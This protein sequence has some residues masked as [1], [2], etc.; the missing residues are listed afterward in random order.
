MANRLLNRFGS[1]SRSQRNLTAFGLSVLVGFSTTVPLTSMACA[2]SHPTSHPINN[3]PAI[4][5]EASP[6]LIEV[7][8]GIHHY[9]LPSGQNVY[10]KP[11]VSQPIITLDTWVTTGSANETE[12]TNGVSHFLEHLLFKG[13]NKLAVGEMD[14]QLEGMGAQFNAATSLD[15]T[16]YY[17]KTPT[18]GFEKALAMHA[19]MLLQ[20]RLPQPELDRERK[21]VQEEINRSQDNPSSQLF[22]ALQKAVFPGHGYAYDTLGPKNLIDSVPRD[23]IG[24]Y[25]ATWYQPKHF[26]TI[27]VGD[28][29]VADA[30]AKVTQTFQAE[31]AKNTSVAM[32]T[33]R[34]SVPTQ[35]VIAAITQPKV[36]ILEDESIQQ[37]Y[38]AM[39]FLA[40]N[41]SQTQQV[42]A[43]DAAMNA[44]GSGRSSRLYQQLKESQNV[45]Q[46]VS[47]SNWTQQQSGL[48]FVSA[49]TRPDQLTDA[50]NGMVNVLNDALSKGI[51]EDEL[52]KA[53]T[54]AIKSYAFLQESTEDVAETIG[55]NV[56]IGQLKDYTEYAAGVQALKLDDVNTALRQSIHPKQAVIVAL[57]PKETAITADTL[58]AVVSS[59]VS[60]NTNEA[61]VNQAKP[62]DAVAAPAVTSQQLANG[63]TL[64]TKARPN[65]ET[66]AI[67]WFF[68]GGK[69]TEQVPGTAITLARLLMKG[70]HLRAQS[71]LAHELDARGLSLSI[72]V[73]DDA[74]VVSASALKE[75]AGELLWI[76]SDML[77]HPRL[78]EEDLTRVKSDLKDEL[79]AQADEPASLVLQQ[80]VQALYP[81]HPYGNAGERIATHLPMITS[82]RVMDYFHQYFRPANSVVSV[83]GNVDSAWVARTL[84][85]AFPARHNVALLAVSPLFRDTVNKRKPSKLATT[86][87]LRE[88]RPKQ[89][90]TW[91]TQ[92]W[93]APSIASPQQFAALKLGNTLLGSGLSSRLFVNLRE[94]QGLAYVTDSQYPSNKLGSRFVLYMGT[95]PKNET[96][97]LKG[98]QQEINRLASE[99]LTEAELDTVKQKYLGQFALSHDTNAHQAYYLGFYE[100]LG[101]GYG[102]DA[103]LPELIHSVTPEQLQHTF[104][105]LLL[106]PSITVIVAPR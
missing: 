2:T 55:Y 77:T 52:A 62:L 70:T 102:L 105:Q 19:N 23:T 82:N 100:S 64:I 33:K 50:V 87:V 75:D 61:L 24:A 13:T 28:V 53:K 42:M 49:E 16:H 38:V 7:R 10:I 65:T 14:A 47:A 30:L 89:S 91:I 57:M 79:A 76:L 60:F 98:L 9:R 58:E 20:A 48:V 78:S 101:V 93:L 29:T 56:T 21:V 85:Q 95:D 86:Q 67:Q 68:K 6:T 88:E 83:V 103:T 81:N 4:T 104:Q 35:P 71:T 69:S 90:A 12:S 37:A 54:Q 25:Y 94:K 74:V 51:T 15:F 43:L 41:A 18:P 22:R 5:S 63:M 17:I 45:V 34:Y 46:S 27:V 39:A 66:V 40:P 99:R 3:T 80:T 11:D 1:F 59:N 92:G 84:D 106:T 31:A 72:G 44:L 97:V 36:V 96:Q 8:S 32:D 73:E 26:H